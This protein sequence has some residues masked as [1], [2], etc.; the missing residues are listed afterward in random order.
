MAE[1]L[2]SGVRGN[3]LRRLIFT[4]TLLNF[5]PLLVPLNARP[6]K[7]RS[8]VHEMNLFNRDL[9]CLPCLSERSVD[10]AIGALLNLFCFYLTGAANSF[11]LFSLLTS[12]LRPP[13]LSAFLFTL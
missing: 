13:S 10:P 6:V 5:L 2:A 8:I 1:G 4:N 12:D 3:G 9:S 7:L 11:S